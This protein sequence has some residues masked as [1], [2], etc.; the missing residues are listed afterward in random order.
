MST[1]NFYDVLNI[2]SDADIKEIKIAYR[3]LAKKYHPDRPEGDEELFGLITEAYNTLLNPKSRVEYDEIY[4]ISKQSESDHFDLK[5][6]SNDHFKTLDADSGSN[7]KKKK[8][9][10]EQKI[11][12]Q[13]AFEDLDKKHGYR[14]DKSELKISDKKITRSLR[15][16][17]LTRQHDDIESIQDKLFEDGVWDLE[18]FNAAFNI[19]YKGMNEIVPHTGRPLAYNS[20]DLCDNFSSIDKYD[21]LYVDEDDILGNSIYGSVK[22]NTEIKKKIDKSDIGSLSGAEYV[23]GHNKK[24]KNYSQTLDQK[25]RER[26]LETRTFGDR[27]MVDFDADD[28]CGGYGILCHVGIK[29]M[30][31][32]SWDNSD[33]LKTKYSKLLEMRKKTV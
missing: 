22:L 3:D 31:S 29:N 7:G 21:E 13:K 26:D 11:E 25:I 19:A 9:E 33:D 10:E 30:G 23:E 2:S 16:L 17:E 27:K 5:A 14:R 20:G 15:D 28:E 4:T 18:K 6:R 24:D 8:S 32:V 1:V 12:F